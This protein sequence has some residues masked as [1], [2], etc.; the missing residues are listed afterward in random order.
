MLSSNL[1]FSFLPS[2]SLTLLLVIALITFHV[3]LSLCIGAASLWVCLC[4]HLTSVGSGVLGL[5]YFRLFV[6]L[7]QWFMGFVFWIGFLSLWFNKVAASISIFFCFEY[8]VY[9][10][11][12]NSASVYLRVNRV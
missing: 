4:F 8:A 6:D 3:F 9:S 7:C 11:F 10:G 1:I 12:N 2:N 5:I